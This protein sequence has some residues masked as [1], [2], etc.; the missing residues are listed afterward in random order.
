MD[1]LDRE[2]RA[3]VGFVA[4]SSGPQTGNITLVKPA[5]SQ[6]TQQANPNAIDLDA[7]VE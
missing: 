5:E 7:M 1:A 3:P 6:K 4:A 2:A